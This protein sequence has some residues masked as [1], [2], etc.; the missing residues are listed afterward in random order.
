MEKMDGLQFCNAV[1]RDEQLRNRGV[2]ILLL[3][4]DS[5][6][7]LHEVSMQVGVVSVLT[8]PITAEELKAE[9]ATAV[10]YAFD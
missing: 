8:K 3:T 7:F 9:I 2:P 1:R 5:N 6:P 4:G 10:G